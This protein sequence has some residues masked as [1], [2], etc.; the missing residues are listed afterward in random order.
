MEF[1]QPQLTHAITNTMNSYI[2]HQ[3]AERQCLIIHAAIVHALDKTLFN[4]LCLIDEFGAEF[5]QPIQ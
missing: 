5:I 1:T 3:L 4:Y 2:H